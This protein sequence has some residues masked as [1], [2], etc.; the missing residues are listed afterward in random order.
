[1]LELIWP[2][3]DRHGNPQYRRTPSIQEARQVVQ[4][5]VAIVQWGRDGQIVRR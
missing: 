1:M 4:L 5:A 2:N 3:P